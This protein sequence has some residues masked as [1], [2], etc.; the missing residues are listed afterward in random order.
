M[1]TRRD[2]LVLM[3]GAALAAK[4]GV[5]PAAAQNVSLG[6]LLK[7]DPLGDIWLGPDN[8]KV[9]IVEYASLTCSHCANFH[10][11]TFKELKKRY[12]DTGQVRFTLREFPL[13]QVDTALYM[14]A[15]SDPSKYY[16]ITDL[17]FETQ[18]SWLKGQA[19][20]VL[21]STKQ[22]LRQAGISEDRFNEVLKDQKLLDGINATRKRGEEV[23]KIDAT[24]TI[25]VN[26]VRQQG[27]TS[28]EGMEK[29]IK[30]AL[31]A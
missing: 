27:E 22:L 23:F 3:G 9:S 20:E 13:N 19:S 10:N 21:L 29:V 6:E 25:F 7:P 18:N 12:I 31:G 28:F 15:R 26:G 2:T 30:P 5:S 8:A 14:V 17:L 4:F 1:I 16:P 24:P 11:T